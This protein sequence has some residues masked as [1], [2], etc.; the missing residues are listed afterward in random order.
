M[1]IESVE[2]KRIVN[3]I[4]KANRCMKTHEI[5]A[6]LQ[7]GIRLSCLIHYAV[8]HKYLKSIKTVKRATGFWYGLP[9]WFDGEQIKSEYMP[10]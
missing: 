7:R 1:S 2:V 5:E 8:Q 6:A 10:P 3:T 9:E 4:A